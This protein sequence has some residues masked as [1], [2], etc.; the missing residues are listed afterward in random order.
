MPKIP[1]V[2]YIFI[3]YIV[4]IVYL[5]THICQ[6]LKHLSLVPFLFLLFASEGIVAPEGFKLFGRGFEAAA[7][8][9]RVIAAQ[10][11]AGGNGFCVVDEAFGQ[12]RRRYFETGVKP[13]VRRY[14]FEGHSRGV[15]FAVGGVARDVR[16]GYPGGLEQGGVDMGLVLPCLDGCGAD[17]FGAQG[18]YD[19]GCAHAPSVGCVVHRESVPVQE[20]HA[21]RQVPVV[22]V[23]V[24]HSLREVHD[25]VPVQVVKVGIN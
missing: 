4:T 15:G 24:C 13:E 1:K 5:Y 12:R 19:R 18:F 17:F 14:G 8:V 25:L 21:V 9:A 22:V 23:C 11:F 20:H 10:G 16:R 6:S 2:I 3:V 7:V